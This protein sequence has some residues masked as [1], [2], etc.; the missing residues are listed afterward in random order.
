MRDGKK[1]REV[2][3]ED[4]KKKIRRANMPERKSEE[5]KR[6][7]EAATGGQKQKNEAAGKTSEAEVD[8]LGNK[9]EKGKAVSEQ[10]F[11]FFFYE[12]HTTDTY[13]C[14]SSTYLNANRQTLSRLLREALQPCVRGAE[15]STTPMSRNP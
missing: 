8:G 5:G 12:C 11:L 7:A 10:C 13:A 14:S 3:S 2:G 6:D 1:S 9:Y 15:T 4:Q